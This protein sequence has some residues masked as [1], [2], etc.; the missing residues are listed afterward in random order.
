MCTLVITSVERNKKNSD[1][2]AVWI[3]GKYTFSI[4]EEDFLRLNL[5]E[6]K[7]ITDQEI[8]HIK[9]NINYRAAKSSAVK[10]LSLKLRCE[11]EVRKKL[12]HE[13]YDRETIENVIE[14][15]KGIGYINDKMY[16]QRF[17]YDRSKLKPKAKKLIKFELMSKGVEE[18][19]IDEVLG[20]WEV[21]EETLA[22]SLLK[23]KFGKYDLND[24]K[25]MKK[26]YAFLQHRGFG[27]EM[28]SSVIRN[29]QNEK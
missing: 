12:D 14:E 7:E 4:S 29:L 28:I 26:A 9:N 17:V 2:L 8:E 5:Y 27:Y 11:E 18:S 6:E 21:N 3:D 13:G 20:D 23:R 25:V 16:T 10:F 1:K 22:E 15:L 19:V 24:E